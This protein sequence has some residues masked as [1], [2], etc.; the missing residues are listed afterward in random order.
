M[1]RR[2]PLDNR[3][4]R[5]ALRIYA[6]D[7]MLARSGDLRVVIE[8]PYRDITCGEQSF[9]D[10]RLEVMDYDAATDHFYRVID[11]DDPRVAM[12]QGVDPSESDP[13]FHQQMVYA[14]ASRV[15][16]NFDRAL[17][18]R[19][20]F[21][22]GQRLRLFPHAF[23][24][25]NAF[26]DDGLNA[27]L[28]G[29]FLAD[30]DDP[31]PNLPGQYVFT[32]LSHDIIA[33]EVAHAALD[34]LHR[35]YREP[36]SPQV[37]ALHEAFADVVAI[38]QRFTFAGVVREVVR[39]TRGDLSRPNPLVEVG[40]Q[41]GAAAGLRGALRTVSGPPDPEAFT[42]ANEP[43]ALGLI[44]VSAIFDGFVRTYERR[45]ADLVRIATGGSGRLP[46]GELHPDLVNRLAAE[47][48]RTAQ[49]VLSMCIRATDYLPPVD[50]SF[51]DFLRGMLTADFELNRADEIGLRAAMIEAFRLR[52]IRPEAVGSLAVES[53]LLEPIDSAP[54]PRLADIVSR[55][56]SVGAREMSRNTAAPSPPPEG[57]R[58]RV[59]R[60]SSSSDR[61][62]LLHWEPDPELL[63]A[64]EGTSEADEVRLLQES[65]PDETWRSIARDLSLWARAKNDL[66]E[67][68]F[69]EGRIRLDG[70]HPVHRSAPSGELLVEMVAQFVQSRPLGD[71]LGGLKYRAGVTMVATLDGRVH[72]LIRKPFH[73]ARE[74]A[75]REWVK[76][77]DASRGP[78][79]PTG[80]RPPQRIAE[81]FSARAMDGRRWR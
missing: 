12:Q 33:H 67:L 50:P 53:L 58:R 40:A 9:H 17:G 14:V 81:A 20:R 27:V 36:T 38:F 80:T 70:F 8:V 18:R 24:G 7:P 28:F 63:D 79:W 10:D 25:R 15:L 32:S 31:G 75:M 62:T 73:Q 44:L 42:R 55:L 66:R 76:A 43:H 59:K 11:L 60:A 52:G 68:G 30:E 41:F 51:S 49:S 46:D 3:P 19:L 16:E 65:E 29:Y 64:V 69:D 21:W 2:S 6:F 61:G 35:H 39:A 72:Y 26:Y 56:L 4:E 47:C 1:S 77:F 74:N 54:D 45:T 13:Q 22:G 71:E 5:R 48:A 78:A 23:Q 37:P 34:R 57:I